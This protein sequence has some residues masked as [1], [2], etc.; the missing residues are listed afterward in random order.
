MKK[1][2][3]QLNNTLNSVFIEVT[4]NGDDAGNIGSNGTGWDE[5]SIMFNDILQ[6]YH[7]IIAGVFGILTLTL[8]LVVMYFFTVLGA[9][10]DKPLERTRAI[11]RIIVCFVVIALF[12]SISLF[13]ALFWGLFK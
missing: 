9:S 11:S 2:I 13:F 10:G 3:Y 12:G 1:I 7:N 5:F 6:K 4:P 8:V